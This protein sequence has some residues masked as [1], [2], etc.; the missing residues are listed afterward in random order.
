MVDISMA[1]ATIDIFTQNGTKITGI[2]EFSD[3][4]TP[5]EIPDFDIADGNM[6]LNGLLV[7]WTKAQAAEFSITLI[8]NSNSDR[9]LSNFLRMHAIGGKGSIPEAFITQLVLHV[10][11]DMTTSATGKK[12]S[13]SYVFSNGR[14]RRGSPAIGSNAEGKMSA[15]TFNFIFEKVD[16]NL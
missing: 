7:T 15:R 4:G 1:G 13:H 16:S 6:N 3:E 14:M 12:S 10:P 11:Q 5:V 8:P 2:S 9:I